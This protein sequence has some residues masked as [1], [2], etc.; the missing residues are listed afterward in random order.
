MISVLKGVSVVLFDL[1]PA[2]VLAEGEAPARTKEQN[3]SL[4]P[5]PASLSPSSGLRT[6][7]PS[8]PCFLKPAMSKKCRHLS[9]EK[10]ALKGQMFM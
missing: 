8:F 7:L 6:L 4:K 3:K 10:A 5:P 2:D 1:H 9:A